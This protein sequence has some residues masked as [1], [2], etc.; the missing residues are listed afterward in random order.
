M[1]RVCVVVYVEDAEYRIHDSCKERNKIKM[2]LLDKIKQESKK[3]GQSKGK[4]IYFRENEKKRIRFLQDMD[5]GMEI[6][7]HDNFE[8]GVNVP[9]QEIFGKSCP[10][11]E[12]EDLRTRSLFAWS[13]FD[14]DANEVKILMQAVNNCT[15]IPAFMSMYENYGTLTDRDYIVNKTGKQQNTSFS[16]V[17]MDKNKFRNDKAKALSNKSLLKFLNQ[18]FPDDNQDDEDDDEDYSPNKYKANKKS[19][20]KSKPE[21]QEDDWDDE[22][23]GNDY[24][25]MSP[26]ELFNLCKERGI[27]CKP[28]KPANYYIN[29]L[30]EDDNAHDDWDDEEDDWEDE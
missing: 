18:A 26:R 6:V 21:P 13:V 16:V 23:T 17:P 19:Y 7:F 20:S 2:G 8:K 5:E 22:E 3:S 29:L 1:Q 27:E 28:K 11:C 25:D 30:E 12:D 24:D 4:F 9:C 15:S 10:Y 14:Y